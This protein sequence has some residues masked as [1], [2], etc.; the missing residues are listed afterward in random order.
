MMIMATNAFG[1]HYATFTSR[2]PLVT[3]VIVNYRTAVQTIAC[4]KSLFL[5]RYPQS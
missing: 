5:V 1:P 3:I 4:V 2:H